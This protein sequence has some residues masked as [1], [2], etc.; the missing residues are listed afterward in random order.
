MSNEYRFTRTWF[1]DVAEPLWI[2][3]FKD[4]ISPKSILEIG[5]FE[6]KATTW[7]CDN[8]IDKKDNKSTYHIIDTF[9]HAE[10]HIEENFYHNISFHKEIDFH[11]LKGKSQY[12]LPTLS[13]DLEIDFAYID[14][15]HR[16]DDTLVDAY[17]VNKLLKSQGI[18]VFDDYLWTDPE[19]QFLVESPKV[20]IDVFY[21]LYANLYEVVYS[22][23]QIIL[24]KK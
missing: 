6:G 20:G 3:F 23:Y 4:K 8:L 11:V 21:N 14:G 17:F 22:G 13:T 7:I 1:N 2:N 9:E 15:S 10:K 5:C 16:G 18:L 19:K 24:I 12:L